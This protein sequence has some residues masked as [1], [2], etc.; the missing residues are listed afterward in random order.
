MQ[1]GWEHRREWEKEPL[2]SLVNW[3]A[4]E[5]GVWNDEPDRVQW[6]H[7]GLRCMIRRGPPAIWCGHVEVPETVGL[8]ESNSLN[9]HGGITFAAAWV[10]ADES[11]LSLALG[12]C[13]SKRVPGVGFDCNH[14][15]D[16]RPTV[17]RDARYPV[18]SEAGTEV[19]RDLQ[20]V[21][22]ETEALAEQIAQR[23]RESLG[24]T[25]LVPS[26]ALTTHPDYDVSS[27][28]V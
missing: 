16:R 8:I 25:S 20:F 13:P 27:E 28:G 18:F 12:E 9:V 26:V 6:M 1:E 22:K 10:W 19:Y 24:A 7:E 14:Y 11:D 5:K 4:Y 23:V 3:R 21:R 17:I 15:G 2:G